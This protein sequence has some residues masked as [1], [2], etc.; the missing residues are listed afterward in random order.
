MQQVHSRETSPAVKPGVEEEGRYLYC[1]ADSGEKASLGE[2]GVEEGTVY[3]I[4]YRDIC[5]VVHDCPAKPYQS[6]DQEV[7][8]AWVVAHQRVVK[9][10]WRRWKTVLPMGF[11]NIVKG[12]GGSVQDWLKQMYEVLKRRMEKVRGK[13][14]YG[15][16]VFWDAKLIA[17]QLRETEPEI[18]ETEEKILEKP[19]GIAYMYLQEIESLVKQALERKANECF[20]DFYNRVAQQVE[21]VR[22]E[23]TKK[24]APGLQM[25]MN[26]SC[27][28]S[29]EGRK[30][31][32]KELHKISQIKGVSV[33]FTGPWPPYSFVV[34]L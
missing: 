2:I 3:T 1:V 30:G 18:L 20:K 19:R 5:A 24:T 15:V 34:G 11:D 10:A 4:P 12:N 32:G 7:V 17:Q 25:I 23:K 31:L 6:D 21:D 22:V 29:K 27:L 13:A 16:Q 33:R 9:A 8:K 14:E 28:V 26:L